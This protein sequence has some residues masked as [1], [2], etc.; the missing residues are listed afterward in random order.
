MKVIMESASFSL[1]EIRYEELVDFPNDKFWRDMGRKYV[2]FLSDYIQVP[3]KF[4]KV[5]MQRL[6]SEIIPE[7]HLEISINSAK[8]IRQEFEEDLELWEKLED[9]VE[10]CSTYVDGY[11]PLRDYDEYFQDENLDLLCGIMLE[12]LADNFS[13]NWECLM[14]RF[15]DKGLEALLTA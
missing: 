6:N 10:D 15:T 4:K 12:I 1:A 2:K 13:D 5:V 8:K 3:I 14:Q 7:F 11:I 9:C